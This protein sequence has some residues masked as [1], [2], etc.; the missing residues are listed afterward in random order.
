M[1]RDPQR[2]RAA[3]FPRVSVAREGGRGEKVC[4]LFTMRCTAGLG[5]K[6]ERMEGSGGGDSGCAERTDGCNL[7]VVVLVNGPTDGWSG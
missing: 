3:Y 4:E 1:S 5:A 2:C 6:E 7:H